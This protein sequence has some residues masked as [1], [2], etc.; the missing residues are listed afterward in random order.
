MDHQK[1]KSPNKHMKQM[2][3]VCPQMCVQNT[4]EKKFETSLRKPITRKTCEL[5]TPSRMEAMFPENVLS[6]S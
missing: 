6:L 1:K 5:I 2:L 3:H 4:G